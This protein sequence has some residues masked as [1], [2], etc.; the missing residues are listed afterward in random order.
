MLIVYLYR[1]L[2]LTPTLYTHTHG[3]RLLMLVCSFTDVYQLI[4]LRARACV[5][6]YCRINAYMI[7]KGG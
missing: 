3:W 7:K 4:V 6:A 5:Y 1:S 2:A